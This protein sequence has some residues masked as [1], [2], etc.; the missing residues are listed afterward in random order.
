MDSFKHLQNIKYHKFVTTLT[1]KY[2]KKQK[3]VSSII[4]GYSLQLFNAVKTRHFLICDA[5]IKQQIKQQ[6]KIQ[7][8]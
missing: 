7:L 8:E 4:I 6:V 1:D 5:K 2:K 3:D